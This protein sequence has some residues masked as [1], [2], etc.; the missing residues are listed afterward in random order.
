MLP[1]YHGKLPW[2]VDLLVLSSYEC[3]LHHELIMGCYYSSSA[4]DTDDADVQ[5]RMIAPSCF[6]GMDDPTMMSGDATFL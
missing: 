4:E 3:Y 2:S 6:M 5:L 1:F